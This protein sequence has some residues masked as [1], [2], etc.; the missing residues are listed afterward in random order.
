MWSPERGRI[1]GGRRCL[2]QE[3]GRGGIGGQREAG[4]RGW[5][6]FLEI[7]GTLL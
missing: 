1:R 5:G 2:G 7:L 3:V 4:D 6:H